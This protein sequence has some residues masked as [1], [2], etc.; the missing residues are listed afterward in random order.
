MKAVVLARGRGRRMMQA[1]AHA[2]LDPTQRAAAA[3]G[4]KAMMPVGPAG[5]PFLDFVIGEL[6]E[7]GCAEVCLVVAPDHQAI[8][9]YYDRQRP[10][11]VRLHFAVQAEAIGTA[12]AVLAAR[13]FAGGDPF[14]VLNA[15]NLYPAAVLGQL[16]ALDGPGLPAFERES[17]VEDSGFPADRVAQFAVIDV[18]A[19]GWLAGISEK[20][21]PR[22]LDAHGPRALIS[23]NVWRFDG[24]IFDACRDVPASA[25]GEFELP[26]AVGL[27]VRRGVRFRVMLARG[28]VVDLSR[29]GDVA[30]VSRL[31]AGREPRL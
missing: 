21:D 7:A 12:D 18:D 28:A 4:H 20:P 24:R 9:D 26:E 29:R 10:S 25:R 30:G 15:D 5:R 23:M 8:R 6:A 19:K 3:A 14:L 2:A 16:A 17:L 31:L 22:D 27:A 11:R 13:G 1:D